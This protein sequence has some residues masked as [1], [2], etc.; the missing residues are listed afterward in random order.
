M[1]GSGS[2][3]DGEVSRQATL[4]RR[5]AGGGR[6]SAFAASYFAH[7]WSVG[8]QW[9]WQKGRA[10]AWHL[11]GKTAVEWRQLVGS[12][13]GGLARLTVELVAHPVRA[14]RP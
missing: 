1:T 8:L 4:A 7:A 3:S 2:A 11:N 9:S 10:H 13:R 5:D 12:V 6:T 14:V